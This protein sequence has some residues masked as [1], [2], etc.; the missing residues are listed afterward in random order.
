MIDT[1]KPAKSTK[2]GPVQASVHS[3]WNWSCAFSPETIGIVTI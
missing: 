1:Q 2:G 3:E